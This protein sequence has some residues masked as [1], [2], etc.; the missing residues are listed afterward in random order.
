MTHPT[1]SVLCVLSCTVAL[2]TMAPGVRA[3]P[4]LEAAWVDQTEQRIEAHRKTDVRIIVLDGEGEP[5]RNAAVRIE[6]Q[7]HDFPIG[8]TLPAGGDWPEPLAVDDANA[9]AQPFAL[10]Q[11]SLWRCFNA[12]ALDGLGDWE[13][14]SPR[15]DAEPD[16][17]PLARQVRR[18]RR[19]GMAVHFG[20][21]ISADLGRNPG[22]VGDIADEAALTAALERRLHD[23]L[24]RTPGPIQHFDLYTHALDHEFVQGR[25]GTAGLR[26]LFERA[27]ALAPDVSL[28]VRVRDALIG[29]RRQRMLQ[30]MLAF[31]DEFVPIDALAIE[32]H[33]SQQ[34]IQDRLRRSLEELETL[35]M[36]VR[37]VGLEIGGHSEAAAAYNAEIVLRTAFASPSVR[38]L[39]FGA[40][41]A[42]EVGT[43]H[44]HL[45]DD[46]G[47]PTAPG[48]VVDRLFA[49]TWW[50]DEAAETD[51]IGNVRAR[52]FAGI[53]RLEADLPDGRTITTLVHVPLAE[54]ERVILLGP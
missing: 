18:A 21:V 14:V 45:L 49:E 41:D 30:R 12:V 32:E 2:L 43:P 31:E 53:H 6:Q 51:A 7:R 44:A 23:A 36:N 40:L 11:E 34:V 20:G 39:W 29:P 48:R 22:W 1:A 4:P 38:G 15:P 26:R 10:T 5:V 54:G 52:I 46:A 25:L 19:T 24:R 33:V 47:A 42:D 27:H 16:L 35:E 17:A 13:R 8:F 9:A 3:Q 28:G 50:T 37:L